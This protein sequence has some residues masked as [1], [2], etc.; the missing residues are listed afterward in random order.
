MDLS[1]FYYKTGKCPERYYNQL[2]GK[3]AEKNY[4][5][6]YARRQEKMLEWME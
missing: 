3:T 1:E 5:E 4:R 6:M 2:N